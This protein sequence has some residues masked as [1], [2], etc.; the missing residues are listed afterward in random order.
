[1]SYCVVVPHYNHLAEFRSFLP[2]LTELDLPLYVI[3]DGSD[4]ELLIEL[5]ELVSEHPNVRLV[6]LG[7][8]RGKGAAVMCGFTIGAADGYSH[9]IQIDADGQHDPNDVPQFIATS[10]KFPDALISGKP[11]FEEG[12]PKIRVYGRRVTLFFTAIETLS[13]QIKDALCGFR[14]Y[15]L[16]PVALLTDKYHVSP[17]MGFDTDILV[18]AMWCSI[19]LRFVDTTVTYIPGGVSHFRY[20]RDNAILARLHIK[21]LIG[22]LFIFPKILWSRFR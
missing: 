6:A 3:D 4:P 20:L 12:A 19:S 7:K 5:R 1:M 17:R 14:V 11:V 18:K 21:L 16:A 2:Q 9:A 10:K 15:P 13:F 8:N 22:L